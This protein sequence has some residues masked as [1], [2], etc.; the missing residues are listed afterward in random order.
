MSAFLFLASDTPFKKLPNPHE[1]IISINEAL[2][3][4][5]EI[6]DYALNMDLDRDK[7]ILLYMDRARH[8]NTKTKVLE[9]G[10]FD[11]DFSIR[12]FPPEEVF[13]IYTEKPYCAKIELHRYT[14]G[15]AKNILAYIREH[16]QTAEEL[17]IWHVWLD[18]YE[19][20]IFKRKEFLLSELSV[21]ILKEIEEVPLTIEPLVHYCY[22][23]RLN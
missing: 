18:D 22:K 13:G 14:E 15:R 6:P 8:F 2:T 23:I 7:P 1:K 4:G 9:D 3:L 20:P 16:L 19:S 17:E 11:D 5:V 12:P 21:S 10:D